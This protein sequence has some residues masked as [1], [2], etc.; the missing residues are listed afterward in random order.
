MKLFI[1]FLM[2][3]LVCIGIGRLR[4]GFRKRRVLG[5]DKAVQSFLKGEYDQRL[6]FEKSGELERLARSLN[7]LG[8]FLKRRM[9]ELEEDK[10]QARAI[11]DHMIEGIV[12]VDANK[13]V[14]FMNPSAQSLFQVPE[15]R[16]VGKTLIETFSNAALDDLVDRAL[17]NPKSMTGEIDLHTPVRKFLKVNAV[18]IRRTSGDKMG[19]LVFVD[20]TEIRRLENLRRE[21]VA[22]VSHELKTPITSL[23]GFIET[24]RGGALED[25]KETQRFL[26]I[27]EEDAA[28]LAG[29]IDGLLELSCLEAHE[30]ALEL[31]PVDVGF[32]IQE[33]ID[34]VKP[35]IHQKRLRVGNR[36]SSQA[37]PKVLAHKDKLKQAIVNLLDNAIKFNQDDG[38]ITI[39][40][41]VSD[42]CVTV[43][44]DD[45][46]IGIP[47][48]A[49]LRVFERFYRVDQA[50]SRHLGGSGLGLAIVK[51]IIEAHGGAVS[52]E[53][54]LGKGSRFSFTLRTVPS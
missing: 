43:F 7:E 8:S 16:N 17:A 2:G 13:R 24:L 10:V 53:S 1:G 5:F 52:C 35:L 33:S 28:R 26:A 22:N 51:H 48:S 12:A 41:A 50:R 40:A 38:T 14:I 30:A 47:E 9:R 3:L 54:C 37:L 32:I 20:V 27:M 44:L 39:D 45:T 49:V 18:G 42:S 15:N 4:Y 29:L 6:S 31:K 11:L 46:G 34:V 19:L 25:A 21:F 23:K 36:V